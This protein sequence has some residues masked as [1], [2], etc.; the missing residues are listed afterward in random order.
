MSKR[1]K[2]PN[3]IK[4]FLLISIGIVLFMAGS[5]QAY[6]YRGYEAIG[7]EIFLLAIPLI[8]K[9]MEDMVRDLVAEIKNDYRAWSRGQW[10]NL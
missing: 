6:H 9:A 4:W 3:I 8:Y 7:G 10:I 5:R 1:R 2:R